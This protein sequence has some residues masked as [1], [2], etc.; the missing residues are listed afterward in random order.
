MAIPKIPDRVS[1]S[2]V[3]IN[4]YMRRLINETPLLT[5]AEEIDLVQRWCNNK[6]YAARNRLVQA[7]GR[8]VANMVK[9]FVNSGAEFADLLNEGYIALTQA[10][11]RFDLSRNNRFSTY[12]AW[13]VLSGL[14]DAVHRDIYTVKIGRSR[15]EKKALRLLGTARQYLGPNLDAS[16][17]E[18]ISDISGCAIETVRRVDGAIS[19]RSI[20]M[21]ASL[22]Q[23]GDGGEMGDTIEDQNAAEHGAE[24][25]MMMIGQRRILN[26]ALSELSDA[27]AAKILRE[28]YLVVEE[29]SLRDIG[30]DLEISSERVRQIEKDAITE[31]QSILSKKGFELET[32]L[33]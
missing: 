4:T 5:E 20:S 24:A 19:S 15:P 1:S 10:A 14:Q 6:D 27:R 13:W 2:D 25:Q 28:R 23:E 18:T 32:L 7:H 16:V 30:E 3:D 9:R 26:E 21:N 33:H 17:F 11:D 12:A 8:L 22:S 31:L 29:R